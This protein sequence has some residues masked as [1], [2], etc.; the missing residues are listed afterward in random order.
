MQEKR[1]P[2]ERELT[3]QAM[4]MLRWLGAYCYKVHGH[5]GQ[6]RGLPDIVGC[7]QGR[8][9]AIEVK[10][11]RSLRKGYR[12][13][14]AQEKELYAIRQAGGVAVVI[15]SIDELVAALEEEFPALKGRLQLL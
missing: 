5:L 6:R 9:L 10:S 13:T 2:T 12:V 15:A 7:L 8:F 14:P 3:Q 11:P 4:K 1:L